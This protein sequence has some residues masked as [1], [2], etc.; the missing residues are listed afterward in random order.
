MAAGRVRCT[1]RLTTGY[2]KVLILIGMKKKSEIITFKVDASLMEVLKKI[3]NRSH[4]IRAAILQALD[5][6]CP[7]CQ[8]TGILTPSQQEHWTRFARDHS[9]ME[10]DDCHELH[11]VCAKPSGRGSAPCNGKD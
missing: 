4:F 2:Y 11:L 1:F 8:G 10:C 6:T 9:L 3:P 7:L 5:A